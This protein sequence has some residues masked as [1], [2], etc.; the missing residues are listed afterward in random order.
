MAGKRQHYVPRFLLRG[1]LA[2]PEGPR[3]ESE[4]TFLHRLGAPPRRVGIGDVGVEDWFY[5][6]K[7][8]PG[9]VTL[10][11][12]ITEFEKSFSRG[13]K[14][15][16]ES[17]PGTL[18]EPA[19]AARTVVHLVMRTAHLRKT[20]SSGI[21]SVYAEIGA[22]FTDP[23][24]LAGL[25]GANNPMLST[26]VTEA[27]KGSARQ[28]VPVGLPEAFSE[29]LLTF[30]VREYGNDLAGQMVAI[31]S[32]LLPNLVEALG[33]K[34]RD[35]HNELVAKPLEDH[36][37]VKLLSQFSW[38]VE[39]GD[40]LILPDAVALSRT[41]DAPLQA[42]LFTG[43]ADVA[44]VLLPLAHDRILVGRR[45]AE[46][47][48]DLASFN[49][50]AAAS[51]QGF[52]VAP[53]AHE[54]E[55]LA[56]TI[57]SG[58]AQAL[59][60]AI[61]E[62]IIDAE[63]VRS[64]A[65]GKFEAARPH[66]LQQE[67]FSYR[68]TLHDFGDEAV[69]KEYADILQTVVGTLSREI[70]LHGLDGFTIASDYDDALAKVDRGDLDLPR[71][72]S[73]ALAY[74]L[75]VAMPV[76]VVRDGKRKEHLVLAAGI[77]E[78]WTSDEPEQRGM[79]LHTLVKML[80]GI[81]NT[82][83]FSQDLSFRPDAIGRELHL[84]V[85]RSPSAYWSAK[86]AAF[87]WPDVGA[88]YADLVLDSFEH[89]KAVVAE[90]RARMSD[91]SDVLDTF[92]VASEAVAAVLGHAA[93]WTGHRDGLAEDQPFDGA[94]LPDRLA[95]HG[96]GRW[97]TLFGRDLAA[98]Y[99]EDG[100][101]DLSVVTTLSRHVE[102]LLWSLGVYCWTEGEDVRCI[103]SDQ[104]LVPADALGLVGSDVADA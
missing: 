6:R 76:T 60:E 5:S 83:R 79:C 54:V 67:E 72:T 47:V 101:L 37:W 75:G 102:R 8:A 34:V 43:G 82:A 62:A 24:R 63:K 58:P 81:A 87:V 48:V 93:D 92:H 50:E 36:G 13:V 89:A 39:E 78:G 71:V 65:P 18:I 2:E 17:A 16:R 21:A 56:M 96:L 69:A 32:P 14:D 77:A 91:S 10:D 11:D 97:I 53:R 33:A 84:A 57:G 31:L 19:L 12:E 26:A 29:R 86:Q 61:S 99:I 74:G 70:P 49:A 9:V 46:E 30:I 23:V 4:R 80:A 90:A 38:S 103:V 55:G 51:C 20:M 35:S 64:L 28:L 44:V 22:L 1:F 98:C 85:A 41:S 42:L 66:E 45:N 52:F 7:G 15:L 25:F 94:D 73:G 88:I 3:D 100:A 59:N 27:I 68:L 40:D 104:P 95:A